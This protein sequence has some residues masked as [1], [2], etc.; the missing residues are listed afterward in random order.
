MVKATK[1]VTDQALYQKFAK[2]EQY[3]INIEDLRTKL[4]SIQKVGVEIEVQLDRKTL[5]FQLFE[6][7]MYNDKTRVRVNTENGLIERR[8]NKEIRTFRGSEAGF[9][10]GPVALTISRDF[11]AFYYTE[12]GIGYFV[13]QYFGDDPTATVNTFIHYADRDVIPTE[14][15]EC[16]YDKI[17]GL[18]KIPNKNANWPKRKKLNFQFQKEVK[19]VILWMLPSLVKFSLPIAI[20]VPQVQKLLCSMYLISWPMIGW[21]NFLQNTNLQFQIFGFLKMQCAIL[22]EIQLIFF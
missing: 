19:D 8:P 21:S 10:G 17:S 20:A 11:L 18:K 7:T 15:V 1:R 13:E 4:E 3:E 22:G 2:V 5:K 6:Y 12:K 14:G 9:S 16:G